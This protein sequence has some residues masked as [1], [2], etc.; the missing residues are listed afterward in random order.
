MRATATAIP[1]VLIVDPKI[2]VDSRGYFFESYNRKTFEEVGVG[3]EFVQDNQSQ[4][5]KHVLRGLHYQ[6]Q[7]PQG[8]LVRTISGA[9]FDVA[10]DLRRSS[11]TFAKWVGVELTGENKRMLWVPRGF[12]HGFLT[13]SDV[14]V[15]AY[16]A[17]NFYA[18]EHERSILWNDPDIGVDWG[19]GSPP[20]LTA[21]D[22]AGKLLRDSE[23]FE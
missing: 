18:P 15:V 22:A 10:V 4:S 6:V 9:I 21:R 14:A 3:D 16:K 1:D 20:V 13:L 12:A 17:D 5:A 19:V 23:V 8:K 2:F 11:P 7:Q